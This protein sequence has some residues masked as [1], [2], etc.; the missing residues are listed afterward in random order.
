MADGLSVEGV[1]N[2]QRAWA[3]GT[4]IVVLA[5][6]GAI[7]A[8]GQAGDHLIRGT[9]GVLAAFAGAVWL[10]RTTGAWM[11]APA[12][13]VVAGVAVIASGYGSNVGWFAA[14]ISAAWMA[15]L[16]P[17]RIATIY[18]ASLIVLFAAEFIGYEHDPGFF[19][20]MG[21]VTLSFASQLVLRRQLWLLGELRKAQAGLAERATLAERNRIARELHDVI[22]HSLTIS[23]MHVSGARVALA[24]APQDADR[25][26]AEAERLTRESLAE[27]RATVGLLRDAEDRQ[28]RPLPDAGALP[29]LVDRLRTA[30][31]DVRYSTEGDSTRLGRAAGLTL[32]RI[33]QEALT[34]AVKHA[35]GAPVTI[36]LRVNP[37]SA[38]LSIDSA[39][40]PKVGGKSDQGVGIAS[41]R[42]RAE[43]V[44]GVVTAGPGGSG[45]LVAAE[46]PLTGPGKPLSRAVS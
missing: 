4:A 37:H 39:G 46:L 10:S 20:W 14:C 35:P 2:R 5:V 22:A 44:G 11:A 27:I 45:W 40:P 1:N 30:G 34:N 8:G 24:H 28:H 38:R 31:V 43:A 32:Y 16:A 29:D 25:A 33:A 7:Q 12:V 3:A 19:A 41:M 23:L 13:L 15:L 42:E 36:A 21:G 9:V 26:L 18:W 17:R 6:G